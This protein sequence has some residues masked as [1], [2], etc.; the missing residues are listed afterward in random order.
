MDLGQNRETEIN[1]IPK[2][3]PAP[4]TSS[5]KRKMADDD[6]SDHHQLSSHKKKS[7]RKT[8]AAPPTGSTWL[9]RVLILLCCAV[10]RDATPPLVNTRPSTP[11][12]SQK[13]N[14]NR[15]I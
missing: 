3:H 7:V 2:D 15:T 5:V 12:P 14:L 8:S 6:D 9:R 1:K 13:L 11:D 10:T 4:S